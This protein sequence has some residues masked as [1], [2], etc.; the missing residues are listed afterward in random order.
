M[1]DLYQ[2]PLPV[3]VVSEDSPDAPEVL[4]DKPLPVF[5][6]NQESGEGGGG[7]VEIPAR[8]GATAK[9]VT[10][11]SLD[12][13]IESGWYWAQKVAEGDFSPQGI[14]IEV[15]KASNGLLYQEI[16]MFTG[17]K[18]R[19]IYNPADNTWNA[20]KQ[21]ADEVG[22]VDGFLRQQYA[23]GNLGGGSGGGTDDA[24]IAALLLD[25]NSETRQA[26]D[27]IIEDQ[28]TRLG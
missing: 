17:S 20:F 26:L 28:A 24:A 22:A 8:L 4:F 2:D 13:L 18:S 27:L 21:I 15:R 12:D 11:S 7:T 16:T 14:F 19:R 10:N 1:S 25:E 9:V 3:M 6:V 5:V 23:D